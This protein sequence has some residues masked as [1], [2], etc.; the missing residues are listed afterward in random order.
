VV[1]TPVG[2]ALDREIDL[3]ERADR[4]MDSFILKCR[5]K[6]AKEEGERAEEEAWKRSERAVV[7]QRREENCQAWIAHFEGQ[8]DRL[9][10]ALRA[11]IEQHRA[12]A[13]ELRAETR[14]S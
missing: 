9:E 2:R 12:R 8:A 3:L 4:E 1:D 14:A 11:L 6:F 5:E 10:D 7:A 13:D